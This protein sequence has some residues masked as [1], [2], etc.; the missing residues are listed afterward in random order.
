MRDDSDDVRDPAVLAQD[1]GEGEH[2]VRSPAEDKD[3]AEQDHHQHNLV[4]PLH[5]RVSHD[6][7]LQGPNILE[8]CMKTSIIW[9][10]N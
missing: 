8:Q 6:L 9:G 7:A 1:G 2:G 5:C 4:L 10:K 3:Q